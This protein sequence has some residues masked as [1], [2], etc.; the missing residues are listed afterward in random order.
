MPRP[1]PSPEPPRLRK[2][3]LVLLL[4]IVLVSIAMV[5]WCGPGIRDALSAPHHGLQR[6]QAQPTS[7]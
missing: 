6:P 3:Y 4:L 2:E 1:T 5:K 7:E